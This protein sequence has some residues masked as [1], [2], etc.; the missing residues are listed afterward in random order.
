MHKTGTVFPLSPASSGTVYAEAIADALRMELGST[1]SATKA[2][3]RWTGASDRAVK[4]WL[5]GTQGPGGRHLI[6]MAGQ[7]DAVLQRVLALAGR[8]VFSLALELN[9][10]KAALAR[11]TAIIDAITPSPQ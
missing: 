6:L 7:S 2:I 11:A 4:Y 5:S 8:D 3:M 10:A 1:Q 9:A